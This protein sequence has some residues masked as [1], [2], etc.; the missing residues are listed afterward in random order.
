MALVERDLR[1]REALLGE[2]RRV[3]AASVEMCRPLAPEAYR[4]QPVE[5]VSPP[6][7]NLGHTSWFFVRNV[8]EPLG[9]RS[10]AEDADFDYVLNSYYAS[11]GERIARCRRGSCT[12]PSTESVYRYR[13]SVDQRV[14]ELIETIADDLFDELERVVTLGLNH[15][16]QHQEL[17]YTEIKFILGQDP[18]RL[19]TAYRAAATDDTQPAPLAGPMRF[20]EFSGGLFEF[21]HVEHGWC[22]DNELP[23]HRRFLE[24]FALADRLV[25][26]GEYLE[27]INDGGYK[28]QLL[29]LD[30][31]WSSAQQEGWEAPLYWEPHDGEW[32]HWTLAGLLPLDLN[33]PVSHVSFYEA[34]A[35]ARWT[36]ETFSEA[37]GARLPSEFQWEQAAR[38]AARAAPDVAFLDGGQLRPR[39]GLQRGMGFQPMSE[40]HGLEAH[41]TQC[42]L[43]QMFG[44]LW[45]W[46]SSYYE[47]YPGYRPFPGALAEYNSKFMDNQRVLRG[48]SCVTPRDHFHLSYRN[49]WPA[50]TRFQFTGLRLARDL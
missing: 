8:L 30:N 42:K 16:Q 6:W 29:W 32:L 7:W 45:Q 4:V 39:G 15:E 47:P 44:A 19:R 48:G 49:F 41:A 24:P 13:A 28:R 9:G 33:E 5:E 10:A 25:T 50:A 23:V 20:V 27:F 11:L 14:A 38:D 17:F 26:N 36:A 12:V 37:S 22:W 18:P 1:A 46:T 35:F 40:S 31:G 34:D 3:R 21:G 2:Y 43:R